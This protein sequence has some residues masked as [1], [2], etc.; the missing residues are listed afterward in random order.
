MLLYF[1]LWIT[2]GVIW[3]FLLGVYYGFKAAIVCKQC[4]IEKGRS[5]IDYFITKP[6]GLIVS[7]HCPLARLEVKFMNNH[8]T[9][10]RIIVL[11]D[12]LWIAIVWPMYIPNMWQAASR[13]YE[14][15]VIYGKMLIMIRTIN[16]EGS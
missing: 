9:L 16:K 14:R 15:L 5:W 4:N 10:W 8:N 3:Q 7:R 6:V 1:V 2:V 13:G 12:Y 11:F